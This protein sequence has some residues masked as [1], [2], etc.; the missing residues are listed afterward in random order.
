MQLSI[1][2]EETARGNREQSK[3]AA[4]KCR[5]AEESRGERQ[6]HRW[7]WAIAARRMA[8]E[9]HTPDLE[10]DCDGGVGLRE[11][12]AKQLET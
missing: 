12:L 6:V 2:L 1:Q 10:R 11:E 9:S 7:V 3:W 4:D 5:A 8:G